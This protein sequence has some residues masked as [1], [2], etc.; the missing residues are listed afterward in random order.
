MTFER[1]HS[2]QQ[3]RV[4]IAEVE[5]E[6]LLVLHERRRPVVPVRM[7]RQQARR[8]IDDVLDRALCVRDA[9]LADRA[10][11]GRR[12]GCVHVPGSRR[13]HV[14]ILCKHGVQQRCAGAR[15]ADDEDRTNDG[16]LCDVRESATVQCDAQSVREQPGELLPHAVDLVRGVGAARIDPVDE[17]PE[18]L[19]H[20]VIC[21]PERTAFTLRQLEQL[22]DRQRAVLCV[23]KLRRCWHGWSLRG[24]A[25]VSERR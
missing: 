19:A 6:E 2:I 14:R 11:A 8:E 9:P 16:F 21:E 10:G 4:R 22:F 18:A 15:Q 20:T 5:R 12:R 13:M 17:L 24:R 7:Q 25:H 3:C 23:C 1:R